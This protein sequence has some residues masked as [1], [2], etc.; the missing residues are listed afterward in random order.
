MSVIERQEQLIEDYGIIPDPM[1]RFQ[2]IVESGGGGTDPFPEEARTEENLVPGCVSKVWV[3]G[4][5][6]DGVLDLRIDSEAPA[7]AAI[8]A[9]MCRLYSGAEVSAVVAV[10]PDFIVELGI[11]R[12]LTPTRL[13]GLGNI[14]KR[15]VELAVQ[16][17]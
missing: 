14:R 11:D 16:G 13:R 7:L 2:L 10:E 4:A 6:K 1:E 3:T 9:L 15:I 17:M 5:V 8:G 12:N